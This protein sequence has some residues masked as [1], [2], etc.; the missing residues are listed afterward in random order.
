LFCGAAASFASQPEPATERPKIGLALGGGSERGFAHIGVIRWFEENNIP[1]DYVAGTSM[2][3]LVGG[4]YATGRSAE[5]MEQLVADLE[6]DVLFRS[7]TPYENLDFRR[8]EDRIAFPSKL[9]FGWSN[10]FSLPS[11][12]LPGTPVNYL[13]AELTAPYQTLDHFDRLPTPYRAVATDIAAGEVVVFEDGSLPLAM[14]ASISIPG[15]FSPIEVDDMVLV[16]G[17]VLN[18]VPAD[19]VR[20][21][22][23]DVVIAVDVGVAL[24]DAEEL[25]SI[26]SV[27]SQTLS[28][29]LL[30]LTNDALR[31][32]D[33]VI[34]PDLKDLKNNSWDDA[35]AFAARGYEAAESKRMLL[36]PL[37]LSEELYAETQQD[38]QERLRT[39]MPKIARIEIE[40]VSNNLQ[41]IVRERISQP[42]GEP[43]D[44]DQLRADCERSLGDGRLES[45]RI[46]I[47][48]GDEQGGVLV[49]HAIPTSAGP[50]FAN[51]G[52]NIDGTEPDDVRFMLGG[53]YV[54]YTDERAREETR[55]DASL[56]RGYGLTAEIHNKFAGPNYFNSRLRLGRELNDY[57]ED[58]A[59]AGEIET[60]RYGAEFALGRALG[61]EARVEAGLGLSHLAW[62]PRSGA[63]DLA[64]AEGNEFKAMIRYVHLGQDEAF[65]ASRGSRLL[66]EM[67][68]Y[69]NLPGRLDPL[70]TAQAEASLFVPLS[71]SDRLFAKLEGGTSFGED[72]PFPYESWLGGPFQLGGYS[73]AALR[74]DNY[75]YGRLGQLSRIG[76]NSQILGLTAYW[77]TWLESG[78]AFDAGQDPSFRTNLSGGVFLDSTVGPVFVGASLGE[79]AQVRYYFKVGHL[80]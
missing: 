78:A 50:P 26:T 36:E 77:G 60:D 2:G 15:A 47:E 24:E 27:L 39:E 5:E 33:I 6:W 34:R 67:T 37:A 32:A 16:D 7:E 45:I 80:F 29:M 48:A 72:A 79:Q 13:L 1:I 70:T 71:G 65:F 22:G 17:G 44:F 20:Q 8:K 3:S 10:G 41:E 28:V 63:E 23:A 38:R 59:Q 19:V 51:L 25:D 35:P 58:S 43:L 53:R 42:L 4:L 52:L 73:P 11:G 76:G 46:E 12:F 54:N 55:I 31:E 57:Y 18:M 56:G 74:G 30:R 62:R 64:R 14:R 66:A 9:H 68:H 49:V 75:L 21:M 61:R 69:F 40:G